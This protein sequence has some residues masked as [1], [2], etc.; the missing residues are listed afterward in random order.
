MVI[1]FS[2][3]IRASIESIIAVIL[4]IT[5]DPPCWGLVVTF[6]FDLG[7][8]KMPNCQFFPSC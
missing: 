2:D 4:C 3:L 6:V 8:Y 1:V 7:A 5:F